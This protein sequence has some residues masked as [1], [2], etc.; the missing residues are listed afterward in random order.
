MIVID[1]TF[2]CIV[3]Q[4]LTENMFHLPYIVGDDISGGVDGGRNDILE[5]EL[6]RWTQNYIDVNR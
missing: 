4:N 1:T 6:D 2:I 5:E 3:L